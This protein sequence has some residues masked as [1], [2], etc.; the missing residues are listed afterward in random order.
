MI[1]RTVMI[2]NHIEPGDAGES[3]RKAMGATRDTGGFARAL[4][5]Q[6][7]FGSPDSILPQAGA[8]VTPSALG[9][10]FGKTLGERAASDP[11]LAAALGRSSAESRS[12]GT[13]SAGDA[14][15]SAGAAAASGEQ[16]EQTQGIPLRRN[17]R[18]SLDRVALPLRR[19][20]MAP[21]ISLSA[22]SGGISLGRRTGAIALDERSLRTLSRVRE[23]CSVEEKPSFDEGSLSARFESGG[24][25]AG[26]IGY[27]RTG[28]T[29]YGL[30]QI[31]SRQGTF[32]EFLKYLDEEAPSLAE[33]L[34]AAGNPNTGNRSGSVPEVWKSIA[35]E[36]SQYFASLQHDFIRKTHFEPVVRDVEK[37]LG[38]RKLSEAMKEV[39]WS[40]SV[41]H[42]P[43]GA[44]RL[45]AQAAEQAGSEGGKVDERK[46]IKDVY[47]LRREQFGS[48]ERAVRD[49]VQRRL[50][51]ERE[52]ALA[53]VGKKGGSVLA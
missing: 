51:E 8:L 10:V 11:A 47:A 30:Y 23:K 25:G 27:D 33:R 14:G 13:P 35:K 18:I 48:S 2:R 36:D 40:T 41:Q 53:M 45:F 50:D 17:S 52:L 15:S 37:T 29:S 7:S 44:R 46:L 26:A 34:R 31:S 43:N 16:E 3:V 5:E 39:V 12:G 4:G 24:D 9:G 20:S 49:A 6:A 22:V 42:G 32:G 38:V 1:E 28:G 21:G 19:S